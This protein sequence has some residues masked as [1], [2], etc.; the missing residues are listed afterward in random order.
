MLQTILSMDTGIFTEQHDG[1]GTQKK[2]ISKSWS[3]E[4][5]R[6][7]HDQNLID[8]EGFT[9]TVMSWVSSAGS[10][11]QSIDQGSHGEEGEAVESGLEMD[12]D[13]LLSK[14]YDLYRV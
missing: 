7:Q 10:T 1:T 3:E 9:K 8:I 4:Q 2:G 5:S 14:P 13:F 11:D 12:V 6:K